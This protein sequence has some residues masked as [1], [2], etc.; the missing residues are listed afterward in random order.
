MTIE[1]WPSYQA[2]RETAFFCQREPVICRKRCQLR[3]QRI[4]LMQQRITERWFGGLKHI[5]LCWTFVRRVRH[6]VLDGIA[7]PTIIDTTSSPWEM[8][9]KLSWAFLMAIHSQQRV[10]SFWKTEESPML[11]LLVESNCNCWKGH[12]VFGCTKSFTERKMVIC[13]NAHLFVESDHVGFIV[14]MNRRFL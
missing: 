8:K 1:N 11:V 6:P 5:W 9:V 10:G 7:A 2:A 14:R 12:N 13:L 4:R 3:K